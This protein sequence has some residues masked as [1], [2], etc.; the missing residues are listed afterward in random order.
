MCHC[1][2]EA[3]DNEYFFDVIVYDP[4]SISNKTLDQS[5]VDAIENTDFMAICQVNG[6][7]VPDV[8]VDTSIVVPTRSFKLPRFYVRMILFPT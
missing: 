1:S 6:Y 7:P 5:T 8:R 2:N 3:G 4:P